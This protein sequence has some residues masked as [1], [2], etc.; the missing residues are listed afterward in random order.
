MAPSC[1][2]E[3]TCSL[4][5]MAMHKK[6]NEKNFLID[7]FPRNKDNLDG[8]NRTMS[9]VATVR[10]VLVLNWPTDVCVKRRRLKRGKISGRADNEESLNRRI[11]TYTDSTMPAIEHYLQKSGSVGRNRLACT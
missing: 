9:T 1:P 8:W 6:S 3:T 2:V 11:T 4:L 10:E 7:G 5:K